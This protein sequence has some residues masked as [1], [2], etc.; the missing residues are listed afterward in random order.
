MESVI[1]KK[2]FT[3][4]ECEYFKSLSNNKIFNRSTVTKYINLNIISE[5]RTSQETTILLDDNLSNIILEKVKEFGIKTLPNYFII[6]KYDKNQEFKKHIDSGVEY[7]NR[8]KTLIIQLS[9]SS[10][11]KGGE[12]CIYEKHKELV[13]SKDIGNTIMFDSSMEHCANK[14][15]DG[16]R[17]SMVFWLSINN[18]GLN[19]FLI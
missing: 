16:I 18:F 10:E 17:Y 1:Q 7:P 13:A 11:Y 8:Y 19:K 9:D 2:L 5:V 3:K 6:L 4:T 14:I 12:L 15:E